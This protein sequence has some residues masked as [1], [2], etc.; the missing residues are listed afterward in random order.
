MTRPDPIR[1]VGS[2]CPL[3]AKISGCLNFPGKDFPFFENDG[4]K[5]PKI[6][7]PRRFRL[8]NILVCLLHDYTAMIRAGLA[9]NPALKGFKKEPTSME[10][11]DEGKI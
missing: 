6:W 10:D 9:L 2:C 5:S 4:L 11:N 1:A 7:G 3:P 8:Q